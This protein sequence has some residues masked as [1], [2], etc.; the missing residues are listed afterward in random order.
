[1]TA[2]VSFHNITSITHTKT[3]RLNSGTAYTTINILNDRGEIMEIALYSS[4][5]DDLEI[6]TK[7]GE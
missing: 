5:P 4:N 6:V 7:D 2:Y 3:K 1:M